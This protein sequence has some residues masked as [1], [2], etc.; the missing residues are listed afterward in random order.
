MK[1]TDLRPYYTKVF[2]GILPH[3]L[4][5]RKR[6]FNLKPDMHSRCQQQ[7]YK[8]ENDGHAS[9]VILEIKM[10]LKVASIVT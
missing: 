5:S 7:G 2:R 10:S 1:L 6:P 9:V 3:N 4:L 8:V